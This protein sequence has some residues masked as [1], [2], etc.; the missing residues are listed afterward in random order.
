MSRVATST[1]M[2]AGVAYYGEPKE[3]VVHSSGHQ[4]LELAETLAAGRRLLDQN[5]LASGDLNGD[6]ERTCCCWPKTTSTS[7]PDHEPCA[8][9]AGE[10][11]LFRHV[12]AIQIL[13]IDGDGREDL[14]LVN[15]D[16]PNPFRS[17]CKPRPVNSVRRF[18]LHCRR[19]LVLG[20]RPRRRPQN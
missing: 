2:T 20:G 6:G 13:D 16:S 7:S 3:L 12:R 4:R 9:R 17:V 11:P 5:G 1:E 10:N 18:I 8:R 15:W 19:P 14:L